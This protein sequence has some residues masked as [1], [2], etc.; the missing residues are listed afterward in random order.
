M[1]IKLI[2]HSRPERSFSFRGRKLPICSRC[3][4]FYSF[5]VLG[6]IVPFLFSPL[7]ALSY[8]LLFLVSIFAIGPMA[9]DGITQLLGWRESNNL[10]RFL[11]GSLAGAI[12]GIDIALL[13]VDAIF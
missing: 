6:V 13:F 4:G 8:S 2:C 10:L 9:L 3:I 7:R 1:A 5:I 12:I 11:T